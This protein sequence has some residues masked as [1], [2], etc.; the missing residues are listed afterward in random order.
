MQHFYDDLADDYH[1]IFR[2]WEEAIVQQGRVLDI[3]IRSRLPAALQRSDLVAAL[4]RAG[5]AEFEWLEPEQSGYYQ[6]MVLARA[7]ARRD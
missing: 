7:G 6:P 1:L 3:E 4:A 2:D 5:F